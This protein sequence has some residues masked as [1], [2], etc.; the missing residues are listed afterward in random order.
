LRGAVLG[1][2]QLQ[3]SQRPALAVLLAARQALGLSKAAG[4]CC[5]QN[6]QEQHVHRECPVQCSAVAAAAACRIEALPVELRKILELT[7]SL[8]LLLLTRPGALAALVAALA[9]AR[10]TAA[11][12]AMASCWLLLDVPAR[13]V[14]ARQLSITGT[15]LGRPSSRRVLLLFVARVQALLGLHARCSTAACKP[16]PART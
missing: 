16:L 7:C 5:V 10:Y 13:L 15:A 2:R 1:C 4:A 14:V 3:S 11:A 6:Q 8:V 9:D 12:A